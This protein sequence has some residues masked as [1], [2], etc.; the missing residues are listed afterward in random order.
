MGYQMTAEDL[1]IRLADL[2][3]DATNAGMSDETIFA[4]IQDAVDALREGLS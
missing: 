2:I 3:A 1:A 4:L